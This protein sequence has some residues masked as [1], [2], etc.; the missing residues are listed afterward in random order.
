[1]KETKACHSFIE[2]VDERQSSVTAGARTATQRTSTQT[3][4]TVQPA[5]AELF[6]SQQQ[7]PAFLPPNPAFVPGANPQVSP[8]EVSGV[9]A[10]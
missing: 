9:P 2:V 8:P 1:M 7:R 4:P 6:G 5:I 10:F 3:T